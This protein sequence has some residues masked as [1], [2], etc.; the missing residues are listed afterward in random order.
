MRLIAYSDKN[1]YVRHS[2]LRLS[3]ND[4]VDIKR[5]DDYLRGICNEPIDI[6]KSII[7]ADRC[8]SFIEGVYKRRMVISNDDLII[9]LITLYPHDMME[10]SVLKSQFPKEMGKLNTLLK[11]NIARDEKIF[12]AAYNVV[13]W[14]MFSRLVVT[15]TLPVVF[16]IA[17]LMICR[18]GYIMVLEDT[19]S[20]SPD[21]LMEISAVIKDNV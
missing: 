7:Q 3:G 14:I 20:V 12:T 9:A 5:L 16:L 10:D 19:D 1:L 13:E 15:N 4:G 2:V 11:D 21:V 18:S 8:V 6:A 17:N